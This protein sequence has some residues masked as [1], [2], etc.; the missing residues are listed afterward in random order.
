MFHVNRSFC[1]YLH[2]TQHLILYLQIHYSVNVPF[3]FIKEKMFE[4]FELKEQQNLFS[5]I[6]KSTNK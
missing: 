6:N 4:Q 2:V 1:F 5:L 3:S